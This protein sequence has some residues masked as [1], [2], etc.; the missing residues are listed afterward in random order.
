MLQKMFCKVCCDFS[1]PT[2]LSQRTSIK[3]VWKPL[4]QDSAGKTVVNQQSSHA[5]VFSYRISLWVTSYPYSH[6]YPK[7]FAIDEAHYYQK[8]PQMSDLGNTVRSG[9][10][11]SWNWE[12]KAHFCL[13]SLFIFCTWGKPGTVHK[14]KKAWLRLSN[15]SGVLYRN[16]FK[17]M[18][19]TK[20]NLDPRGHLAMPADIFLLREWR[21]YRHLV[22]T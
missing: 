18:V 10:D 20:G 7:S 13:L 14:T 6:F 1:G 8:F 19:H 21:C 16:C 2:Q 5:L 9:P 17:L 15:L 22:R 11:L 12:D 3:N 4:F